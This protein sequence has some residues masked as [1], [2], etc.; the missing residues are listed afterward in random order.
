M[1]RYLPLAEGA[2]WARTILDLNASGV[3]P[4]PA[5]ACH[6]RGDNAGSP[7]LEVTRGDHSSASKMDGSTVPG[8]LPGVLV[9][10]AEI[11][12]LE[13]VGAYADGRGPVLSL[14]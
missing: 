8:D 13:K 5:R 7:D 12:K 6:I 11:E 10:S 9:P 3:R 14:Y 4:A 2:R 1:R